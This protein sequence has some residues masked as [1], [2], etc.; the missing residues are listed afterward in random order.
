MGLNVAPLELLHCPGRKIR[1]SRYSP[2]S[3]SQ[4]GSVRTKR[5]SELTS[6]QLR[7]VRTSSTKNSDSLIRIIRKYPTESTIFQIWFLHWQDLEPELPQVRQGRPLKHPY[8]QMCNVTPSLVASV[9]PAQDIHKRDHAVVA[10]MAQLQRSP[11]PPSVSASQNSRK[12]VQP[13]YIHP[14]ANSQRSPPP[15]TKFGMR[16]QPVDSNH[17][18]ELVICHPQ[19]SPSH[20]RLG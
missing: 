13:P 1:H 16:K 14:T 3:I 9:K 20:G 8:A 18:H 7:L 15:T 10:M 12:F 6:S 2:R 5:T 4:V 17:D 11:R 19:Q